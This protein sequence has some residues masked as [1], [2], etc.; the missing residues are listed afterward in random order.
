MPDLGRLLTEPSR[1]ASRAARREV[2]TL[3][4]CNPTC[5]EHEV[6]DRVRARRLPWMR[7][8]GG[9][10]LFTIVAMPTHH[11]VEHQLVWGARSRAATDRVTQSTNCLSTDP[12][13]TS[14]F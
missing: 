5:A 3:W 11:R 14:V 6:P 2:A 12:E 10:R 4:P 8:R 9:P 7:G 1:S 13:S